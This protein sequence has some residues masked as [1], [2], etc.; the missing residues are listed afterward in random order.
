MSFGPIRGR[1]FQSTTATSSSAMPVHPEPPD[2]HG[3]GP[4]SEPPKEEDHGLSVSELGN[5]GHGFSAFDIDDLEHTA[6][7]PGWH[8]E[9]GY[10]VLNDTSKDYW[11]VKAGCLIRHHVVPRRHHVVPLK[12]FEPGR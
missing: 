10:I 4:Y 2:T 11:E 5:L 3:A 7:P 8:V 12:G 9:D 1:M 6:L